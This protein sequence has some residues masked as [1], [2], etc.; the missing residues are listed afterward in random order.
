MQQ[1]ESATAGPSTPRAGSS[2]APTPARDENLDNFPDFGTPKFE[3]ED[4]AVDADQLGD[5]YAG[6]TPRTP[7]IDEDAEG[8]NDVDAPDDGTTTGGAGVEDEGNLSEPVIPMPRPRGRPRGRGRGA[9]IGSARARGTTRGRPRGRGRGRGG[10]GSGV[11]IRLPKRNGE[12]GDDD[13]VAT[14]GEMG[15]E[16]YGTLGVDGMEGYGDGEVFGGGKPSRTIQGQVYIIDGDEFVTDDDPK[17][18][19]KI[20]KWGNLLG[21]EFCPALFI[22]DPSA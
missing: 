19:E 10:R 1:R 4:K 7:A 12:E 16:D 17:G 9:L 8:G 15:P 5:D 6:G 14:P 21:G 18:D 11:T 22:F 13:V 20:D 3:D 2:V